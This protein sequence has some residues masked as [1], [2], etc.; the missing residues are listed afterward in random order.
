MPNQ[1]NREYRSTIFAMLF[2]D[3]EKLKSL[4][5][6]ISG[7]KIESADDITLNTLSDE[8][9]IESGIFTRLKNDVSFIFHGYQKLYE[10]QSTWS[11]NMPVRML[12]YYAELIRR[13]H[14][15]V[16]LYRGKG[17][18]LDTPQFVVF[19]NGTDRKDMRDK[20]VLKLS[21][22]YKHPN[23]QKNP[24]LE[25][26]VVVYNINEGHNPELMEACGIMKQYSEFVAMSCE[27]LKGIKDEH[28]KAK[29]METV[30][31]HC[32]EAGILAEF[33]RENREAIIM[34]SILEF[35]EDA[36]AEAMRLDGYDE[37]YDNGYDDGKHGGA[38]EAFYKMVSKGKV[39]PEEAAEECAVPLEEFLENM[40]AAGYQ[41]PS[42]V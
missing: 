11:A 16:S 40:T 2:S 19:Y 18:S 25:L 36:F 26:N 7:E 4:C 34:R 5:E 30:L 8:D 14:P 1:M 23:G 35:D 24:S 12:L 10:H 42:G 32:L 20:E 3:K 27:A 37:G 39:T 22:L 33:I 31:E 41:I 21:S 17:I 15:L 6:A 38:L 28:Q 9:G 29:A 13:D